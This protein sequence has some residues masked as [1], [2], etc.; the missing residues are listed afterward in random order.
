MFFVVRLLLFFVNYSPIHVK[1]MR[2]LRVIYLMLTGLLIGNLFSCSK[3]EEDFGAQGGLLPT[4]YINIE[5]N[6][7]SPSILSV[8]N[9]S[10]IT[11]LNKTTTSHT[12]VSADSSTILSPAIASGSY[13]YVKPDTLAGSL[14]VN[15]NYHCKEHPTVTGTI[16]LLP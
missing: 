11:F 15:I 4:H 14:P 10:S 12:I 6:S 3:S 2:K 16:I 13:F 8:A 1:H 7:F 5:D 9:G